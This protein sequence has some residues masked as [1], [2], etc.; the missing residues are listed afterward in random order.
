MPPQNRTLGLKFDLRTKGGKAA[1]SAFGSMAKSL[2]YMRAG[3]SATAIGLQ[4]LDARMIALTSAMERSRQKATQTT[5][6]LSQIASNTMIS[7]LHDL[8]TS[9]EIIGRKALIAS[10]WI[11]S[12]FTKVSG[13]L[14]EI[15]TSFQYIKGG[16][17]F[18]FGARSE[19]IMSRAL[20][21]AQRTNISTREVLDVTRSLGVI[22]INPFEDMITKRGET[23]SALKSL[24]DL[25]ALI[26][27]QGMQGALFAIRNAL[28]GQWRSLQMRFDIPLN[29]IDEIII[30]I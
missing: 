10:D 30:Y 9:F 2:E 22:K 11:L 13:T 21:I 17:D 5:R 4:R 12:K 16:L 26:P 14:F 28:S 8:A 6:S 25:A 24:A 23:Q 19:E 7:R 1:A 27:Q 3:A 18:A 15:G 29:I 20:E